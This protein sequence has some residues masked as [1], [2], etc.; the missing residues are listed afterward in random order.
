MMLLSSHYRS[1]IAFSSELLDQSTQRL[2]KIYNVLEALERAG[3]PIELPCEA[4]E[5]HRLS[6]IADEARKAFE[7]AMDDDFNTPAALA[8][9][10]DLTSR[11]HRELFD[12]QGIAL[13][14]DG[15]VAG[16]V[17]LFRAATSLLAVLGFPP[18]RLQ[19]TASD[20][21]AQD[22]LLDLLG[23][24]RQQARSNKQYELGDQIRDE[25]VELGFEI[26]DRP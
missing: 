8:A 18:R 5:G 13:E 4:L 14:G 12:H 19:T 10:H 24:L 6:P 23:R 25:L 17:V 26:R 3:M 20:E 11:T 22:G 2:E 9:I 21:S 7:D 15:V 1:P 16:R